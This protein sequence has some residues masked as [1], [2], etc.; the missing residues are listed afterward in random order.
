MI[1]WKLASREKKSS[2][3]FLA[4]SP[5]EAALSSIPSSK[6][7]MVWISDSETRTEKVCQ[8][9]PNGGTHASEM[10]TGTLPQSMASKSLNV[11]VPK[12]RGQSTKLERLITSTNGSR[13]ES[14]GA[15]DR[16]GRALPLSAALESRRSA[17][18]CTSRP[19]R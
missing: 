12:P 7:G 17:R 3:V 16:R 1:R 11:A 13:K 6:D 15:S 4:C 18:G 9:G 2:H 8:S 5:I 14:L 19:M 10:M